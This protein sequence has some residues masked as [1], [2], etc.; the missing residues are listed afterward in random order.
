MIE[1]LEPLNVFI[2]SACVGAIFD[3]ASCTLFLADWSGHIIPD[4]C[5]EPI[6]EAFYAVWWDN[7]HFAKSRPEEGGCVFGNQTDDKQQWWDRNRLTTKLRDKGCAVVCVAAVE[8]NCL[9]C[10]PGQQYITAALSIHSQG[11]IRVLAVLMEDNILICILLSGVGF[12]SKSGVLRIPLW[13]GVI[14]PASLM[15]P[16]NEAVRSFWRDKNFFVK[17]R[18]E[19]CVFGNQ[20]KGL[21]RWL[22]RHERVAGLVAMGCS[23]ET[24]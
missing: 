12:D 15:E 2:E 22:T 20:M 19:G 18:S 17:Q 16:V 11:D 6:N 13:T 7:R 10:R 23:V 5:R 14:I 3:H 1:A 8:R 21:H 24:V 4:E 9:A